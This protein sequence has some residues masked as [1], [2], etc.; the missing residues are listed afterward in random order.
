MLI[1]NQ[2]SVQLLNTA[3][4]KSKEKKIDSSYEERLSTTC[5][6]PAIKALSLAITQLSES[7]NIS[8]DQAAIML[9]E[10]VRELDSIWNDYVM[11]EGISRLKDML[12]PQQL[13]AKAFG[14][15]TA[16]AHAHACITLILL[17]T[18]R[19]L[20]KYLYKKGRINRPFKFLEYIFETYSQ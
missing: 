18:E 8:R 4:V 15:A 11:M 3:I 5:E 9:V 1:D 19:S 6:T 12:K 16:P 17:G 10:T 13:N 14:Q 20:I 7:E 2:E